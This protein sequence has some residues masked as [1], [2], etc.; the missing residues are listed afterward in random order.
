MS[1]EEFARLR[2]LLSRAA[3]L[4]FD[5]TRRESL[6]YSITERLRATGETSVSAYLD[7]VQS[8]GSPE[9]QELLDEVTIQETH[10]FR[11]PPQVRALRAH[12]VPELVRAAAAGTKRLRIWSAGCSTGEEP[13]TIAM[14][15]RELLPSTA[16][17][18]VQ[19]VA[20]DVSAKALDAARA[21]TYGARSVQLAT[22]G[23]C[24]A[25]L[26]E[27]PTGRYEVR[28]RSALLVTFRT[29]TGHRPAAVRPLDERHDL[30]CARQRHHLLLPG[31]H[32][33][34]SSHACHGP[35]ARRRLPVP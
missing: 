35:G 26:T 23:G 30:V 34:P 4:V 29:T 1:D 3:G 2:L 16:G 13:Y 25:V 22:P 5:E 7:L 18:D 32:A 6:A 21:G 19:V 10:F 15:L 17:W 31:D 9:R 33:A 24:A 12:V 11:N 28:R 27:L 20:T 8:P 14:L